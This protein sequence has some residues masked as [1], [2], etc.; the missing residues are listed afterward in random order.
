VIG[1]ATLSKGRPSHE[2]GR[3]FHHSGGGRSTSSVV[4][5][6]PHQRAASYLLASLDREALD[7]EAVR[8]RG[9]IGS[10]NTNDRG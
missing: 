8:L 9:W 1:L 3:P 6:E 2:R 4:G 5:G 10:D 7:W